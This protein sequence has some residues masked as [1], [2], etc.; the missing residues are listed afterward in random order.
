MSVDSPGTAMGAATDQ[1][2]RPVGRRLGVVAFLLAVGFAALPWLV[3]L[4]FLATSTGGSAYTSVA[5]IVY[6]VHVLGMLAALTLGVL[7]VVNRRGRGWGIA[8]IVISV[9]FSQTVVSMI[10]AV[11]GG[12]GAQP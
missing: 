6:L 2:T 9:L 3:T 1:Q 4:V 7:A 5:I 12:L 8:A 11:F 10:A